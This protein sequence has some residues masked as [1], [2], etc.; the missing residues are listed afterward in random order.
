MANFQTNI[1]EN[2]DDFKAKINASSQRIVDIEGASAQINETI[3][4]TIDTSAQRNVDSFTRSLNLLSTALTQVAGKQ[5]SAAITTRELNAV[6]SDVS[7]ALL[8]GVDAMNLLNNKSAEYATVKSQI[9]SLTETV[10][11]LQQT[12]LALDREAAAQQTNTNQLMKWYADVM[13]QVTVNKISQ[14]AASKKLSGMLKT[15]ATA[16]KG[17]AAAGKGFS[18]ALMGMKAAFKV[19][20]KIGLVVA[21]IAGIIKVVDLLTKR[22]REAKRAQQE[23]EQSVINGAHRPVAAIKNLSAVWNELGDDMEA[24]TRFIEENRQAFNT[25]GVSI[26]SV[27][28]AE[29]LLVKNKDAF[30]D[31]QMQKARAAAILAQTNEKVRRKMELQAQI[32]QMPATRTRIVG[33]GQSG[34]AQIVQVPNRAKEKAQRKLNELNEAIIQGYVDAAN[35]ERQGRQYLQNAGIAAQERANTATSNNRNRQQEQLRREAQTRLQEQKRQQQQIHDLVLSAEQALNDARFNIMEEGRAKRL[36]ASQREF[37]ATKQQIEQQ[38]AQLAAIQGG[39]LTAE[40]SANFEERLRL[41]EQAKETRNQHIDA[42]YERQFTEMLQRMTD[43]LKNEEERRIQAIRARYQ[44]ERDEAKRLFESGA[45]DRAQFTALDAATM[46]A[47]EREMLN[48]LL[49]QVEDFAQKRLDVETR[50]AV[51]IEEAKTLGNEQLVAQL[52]ASRDQALSQLEARMLQECES[53]LELFENLDNLTAT[54][55]DELVRTIEQGLAKLNLNPEELRTITNELNRARAAAEELRAVNP[56]TSLIH[57]FRQLQQ[58]SS[59]ALQAIE[60]DLANIKRIFGSVGEAASSIFTAFGNDS[61]AQKA[62]HIKGIATGAIEAGTG[63]ARLAAGDIVGGIT[64]LASGIGNVVTNITGM[65]DARHQRAIDNIQESVDNLRKAYEELGRQIDGTFSSNRAELL[66]QKNENLKQQNAEIQRQI[67]AESNK[68]RSDAEQIARWN[69]QIEENNR[70][71]KQNKQAARDAIVGTTVTAAI[72]DFAT[73]YV[74]AWRQGQDAAKASANVA[75][76]ILINA[77]KQAMKSRIQPYVERL[78]KRIAAAMNRDGKITETEQA[79]I[80]RYVAQIE[81][82]AGKWQ[83]AFAPHLDRI[84][85]AQRGVTGELQAAMTE[86]TASQLVGLW[87]MT[88]MDIRDIRNRVVNSDYFSNETLSPSEVY[89]MTQYV[90]EISFNTYNTA[91]NTERIGEIADGVNGIRSD[92]A[93]KGAMSQNASATRG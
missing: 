44:A 33:D 80:D 73:A 91:S 30:I 34:H 60:R 82:V 40:Q 23:F 54:Q 53:W 84:E 25:L 7:G 59:T 50:Y 5:K 75:R 46:A 90:R 83:D 71:I 65:R 52:E 27:A 77:L 88:A 67:Q 31:A 57:G 22:G 41:N 16:Y 51:L 19:I 93:A 36:K 78:H 28:D 43:V 42:A 35:A 11:G 12:S 1:T 8:S 10:I 20:P 32:D 55:I 74:N 76:N 86:G 45:I 17:A 81:R 66:D 92:M 21:A 63:I 87:N 58:D 9:L 13:G 38:K 24:Q 2:S 69:A 61:A 64:S 70:K 85:E 79:A 29:N 39:T 26:E 15:V 3:R 68:K 89:N 18:G 62:Q 47:E 56:F 6:L 4:A 49:A 37:E 72:N 14:K 48:L